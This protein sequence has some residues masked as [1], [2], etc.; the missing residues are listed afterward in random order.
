MSPNVYNLKH[1]AKHH[2]IAMISCL[3]ER[4]GIFLA[5]IVRQEDISR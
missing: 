4:R 3:C 1:P 2:G 5:K